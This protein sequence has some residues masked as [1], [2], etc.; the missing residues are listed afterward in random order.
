MVYFSSTAFHRYNKG[1]NRYKS[2]I[3]TN[4]SMLKDAVDEERKYLTL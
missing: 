3:Q 2:P 4:Y 1:S